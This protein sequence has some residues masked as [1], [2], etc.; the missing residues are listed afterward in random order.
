[1][2]RRASRLMQAADAAAMMLRQLIYATPATPLRQL[3]FIADIALFSCWRQ[4][5]DAASFID[6]FLSRHLALIDI[7]L[8][9]ISP[10][11]I[12]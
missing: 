12:S 3:P 5:H 10:L 1:M 9:I 8:L 2:R 11:F 6:T 7:S 4:R